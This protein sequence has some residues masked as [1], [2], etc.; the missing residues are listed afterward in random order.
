MPKSP[1]LGM[2]VGGMSAPRHIAVAL[3][4][5]ASAVA[6]IFKPWIE[7]KQAPTVPTTS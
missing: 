2:P 7:D 5:A 6:L 4:K 1:V 3:D